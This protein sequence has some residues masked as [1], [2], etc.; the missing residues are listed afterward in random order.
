MPVLV[1]CCCK[2]SDLCR[3]SR[4]A[5]LG[6][7]S[8]G[9]SD[10]SI[11]FPVVSYRRPLNTV[12]LLT[13]LGRYPCVHLSVVS[14]QR[15]LNTSPTDIHIQKYPCVHFCIGCQGDRTGWHTHRQKTH[16]HTHTHTH[17]SLSLSVCVSLAQTH[18]A[19]THTHTNTCA[20]VSWVGEQGEREHARLCEGKKR[21][22][23]SLACDRA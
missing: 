4:L 6:C 11:H 10:S 14:Y 9:D 23:I 16:T 18:T 5:L 3:R 12:P 22:R 20:C 15:A 21:T 17:I 8:I 1:L 7:D 19:L 13:S 2:T